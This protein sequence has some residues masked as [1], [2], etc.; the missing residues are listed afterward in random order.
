M[1]GLASLLEVANFRSPEA[2]ALVMAH[3]TWTFAQLDEAATQ[4][5][6]ALLSRGLS[7][8]D[9]VAIWLA[10]VPEAV[11][12]LWG[13]LKAGGAFVMVNAKTKGEKINY[14]LRD[15]QAVALVTDEAHLASAQLVNYPYL[16][17]TFLVGDHTL[18]MRGALA[19]FESRAEVCPL[20][21]P[22]GDDLA[23]ILYTSGTTG[24]PKG[25]ALTHRNIATATRAIAQYLRLKASDVLFNVLP[26]S[27]GY[28]LTQLFSACFAS[29][30]FVCE[31]DMLF[32][33]TTLG[34]VAA[35][36][37]T[38]FAIVPTMAEILLNLDLTKYDLAS[39]RYIT[40][41]GAHLPPEQATQ[42][43]ASLPHTALY[44]MYGQTECLR[45]SYLEPEE[46]S[47]H[48]GSV[49][50]GMPFQDLFLLDAEGNEVDDLCTGELVVRGDH[51]MR[52]Y[53]NAEDATREKLRSP[54]PSLKD[55]VAPNERLLFTGDLFRRDADGF[56]YFISRK[57]DV[58]KS[59]G[60]KVS[61][62]EVER[63][64]VSIPGVEAAAVVG[65][66]R[67]RFGVVIKAFVV[68]ESGAVLSER[69]VIRACAA[70]LEDYMVPAVVEFRD[71]LPLN[72]RG[73]VDY[74]TLK[75]QPQPPSSDR[76]HRPY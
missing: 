5:A 73:K 11:I 18:A 6:F 3:R 28:G 25:V 38:G 32:P 44:C 56:L 13:V 37:A 48:P 46:F 72:E 49:G 31:K 74:A 27:F 57:D 40:N 21:S 8:G 69:D 1:P 36:R 23:A 35:V 65:I 16:Q 63:A 33:H 54:P 61:P 26:L 59:R 4:F 70:R 10:N 75:S 55:R 12:A 22:D 50:K 67:P 20:P 76:P 47:A 29:A 66:E 64:L 39:L 60:E 24:F 51:V 62:A 68:R 19:S 71:A 58:I 15:S 17:V 7:P 53:W 45:I 41:A 2:I 42:L 52:G 14:L 43:A 9:R 30:A 34:K